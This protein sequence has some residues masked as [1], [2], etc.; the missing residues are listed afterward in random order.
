MK[1]YYMNKGGSPMVPKHGV[2]KCMNGGYVPLMLQVHHG[3][4]MAVPVPRP[5]EMT[6]AK[7]ILGGLSIQDQGKKKKYISF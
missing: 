3:A 1:L 4:G 2:C 7:S 6:R 5:V